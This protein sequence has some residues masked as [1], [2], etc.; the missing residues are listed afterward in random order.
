MASRFRDLSDEGEI[1]DDDGF[2][3]TTLKEK[4]NAEHAGGRLWSSMLQAEELESGLKTMPINDADKMVERDAESFPAPQEADFKQPK[5]KLKKSKNSFNQEDDLFGNGEDAGAEEFGIRSVNNPRRTQPDL[6]TPYDRVNLLGSRDRRK[7]ERFEKRKKQQK[8]GEPSS[9]MPNRK[10]RMDEAVSMESLNSI[11]SHQSETS[12]SGFSKKRKKKK[13]AK[14]PENAVLRP[15]FSFDNLYKAS[16][17]TDLSAEQTGERL[18]AELGDK[19]PVPIKFAVSE[20]GIE[21]ALELFDATIETEKSGG[22]KVKFGDR[23]RTPGGVFFK[24][25]HDSKQIS[26]EV[27][28]KIYEFS[29]DYT[30]KKKNENE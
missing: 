22:L 12:Q 9:F 14:V 27:K 18:A 28:K 7:L 3:T 4:P 16:I 6:K 2:V 19:D 15:D 8:V 1:S 11:G 21:L 30:Q 13:H 5:N 20:I 26:D 17:P 29:R 24:H 10:R 23:R 25:L